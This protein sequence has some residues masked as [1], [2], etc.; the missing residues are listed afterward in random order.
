MDAA[1]WISHEIDKKIPRKGFLPGDSGGF[2]TYFEESLAAS[3]AASVFG[4]FFW[5]AARRPGALSFSAFLD[6]E[7]RVFAWSSICFAASSSWTSFSFLR[8]AMAAV[9]VFSYSV[10]LNQE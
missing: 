5:R 7:R 9:A 6:D 2:R 4:Y 8:G 10:F 3:L 1:E